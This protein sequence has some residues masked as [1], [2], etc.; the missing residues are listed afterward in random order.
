MTNLYNYKVA[1]ID[2]N[3]KTK[4]YTNDYSMG[5]IETIRAFNSAIAQAISKGYVI[6]SAK[7]I[8]VN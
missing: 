6:I 8:K 3:N 7:I 4:S 2:S 1:C 5:Q